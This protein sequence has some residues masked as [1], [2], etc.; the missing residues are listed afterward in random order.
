M[1]DKKKIMLVKI[2]V[3]V[4]VIGGLV[5]GSYLL[6]VYASNASNKP[7]IV[8]EGAIEN[9]NIDSNPIEIVQRW[10]SNNIPGLSQIFGTTSKDEII[11]GIK[12][13]KGKEKESAYGSL[14][15]M[16]GKG[17]KPVELKSKTGNIESNFG[18]GISQDGC[19]LEYEKED[20]NYI[21]NLINGD[22]FKYNSKVYSNWSEN[23]EYLVGYMEQEKC[24]SLYNVKSKLNKT[25]PIDE[26]K[27]SI[28]NSF[29]TRDGKEIYFVGSEKKDRNLSAQGIFKINAE[30]KSMEKIF[31]L[32]YRDSRKEVQDESGIAGAD[33]TFIDNG[34]KII[35]NATINGDSGVYIYDIDSKKFLKVIDTMKTKEG[36]YCVSFSVSPDR[37]KIAYVNKSKENK[38]TDQWNI[39]VAKINEKGISNRV[40]IDKNIYLGGHSDKEL[41]WSNDS[42]KLYYFNISGVNQSIE[43]TQNHIN[44]VKFK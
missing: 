41:L 20:N 3:P 30:T 23:G 38:D 36:D 21:Y 32:P 19:R 26:S 44:V 34:K 16:D 39:Y 7:T 35:L 18:A 29:K 22:E 17:F 37:S 40:T 6:E 9:K 28:L 15:K 31:L 24:I 13:V 43:S 33:F 11:A 10:Q 8:S 5:G 27:V 25:I 4:L 2:A 12:S 1:K 42:K 14:Y